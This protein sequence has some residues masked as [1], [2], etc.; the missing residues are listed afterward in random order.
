MTEEKIVI[1]ADPAYPLNGM[2]TLPDD[3]SE[4]VPA[5]VFV[6][7]SGSSNMDEKIYKIT[8]FRDLAHGLASRGIA[9]VRYDKRSFV[10]PL[11]LLRAAKGRL[12][13]KDE[14]IDE[15]VTTLQKLMK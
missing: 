9:S 8:P 13:V 7:G 6:H 1:C 3:L 14:T 2:L 10:H 15:L 12:T 11:K 4:K 5:V